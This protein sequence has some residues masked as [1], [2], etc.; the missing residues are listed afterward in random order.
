MLG[1]PPIDIGQAK[2]IDGVTRKAAEGSYVPFRLNQQSNP[3]CLPAPQQLIWVG[4]K[5]DAGYSVAYTTPGFATKQNA[6][7]FVAPITGGNVVRHQPFMQCGSY[8]TGLHEESALEIVLHMVLEKF[9]LPGDNDMRSATP[10]AM[11][12]PMALAMLS[13]VQSQLLPG[14][15]VGDNGSG[16]FFRRALGVVKSISRVVRD[17]SA[18]LSLMPG[19]IGAASGIVNQAA[20]LSF[21]G[22]SAARNALRKDTK[23]RNKRKK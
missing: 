1:L 6:A 12:D 3:P 20:N 8:F 11:F 13:K 15:P 16:D 19:T 17:V 21:Q 9:P 18:P 5:S 22:S 4:E 23:R 7:G 10:T 14:S 2:Q